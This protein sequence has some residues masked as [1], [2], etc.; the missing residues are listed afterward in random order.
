MQ[1]RDALHKLE[2]STDFTAWQSEH[3]NSYLSY[4]FIMIA[5][6]VQADW[7]LGYY[8]PNK[9]TL[10]SF[11]INET[12]IQNPDAEIFK[13]K[14]KVQKLDL[15]KVK[16]NLDKALTIAKELQ[17]DKYKGHDPIKKIVILQNLDMGQVWNITYVTQTFKTLNIK[18]N[19]ETGE[20]VKYDLIDLFK[21]EK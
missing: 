3:K 7:Q 1:F 14:A 18:I 15:R 5:S 2:K 6:D 11:T 13:N 17:K 10:T 12:I 20:I 21:I 9:D 19:S 4:G 16:I 8:N